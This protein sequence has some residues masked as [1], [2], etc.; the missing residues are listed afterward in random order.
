MKAVFF[1]H[2]GKSDALRFGDRPDPVAGPG[3][4]VVRLE[5]A[6]MNRLDLFVLHGIPGLPPRSR[7][8]AAPTGTGAWR[9]SARA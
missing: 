6:A 9:R 7:T 1:D 8:S 5:A 3:E 4:V 2:H